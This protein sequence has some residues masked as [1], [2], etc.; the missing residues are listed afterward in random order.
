MT[1][2][3]GEKKEL[4]PKLRFPEFVGEPGWVQSKIGK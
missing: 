4:V 2:S 3:E 1:K